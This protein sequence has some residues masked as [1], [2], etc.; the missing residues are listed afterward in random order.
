MLSSKKEKPHETLDEAPPAANP[1]AYTGSKRKPRSAIAP[2]RLATILTLLLGV[3][4]PSTLWAQAWLENPGAGSFQSGIGVVSGW[5]CN[6]NRIEV[7]FDNTIRVQAGY[8]TPRGDTRAVC[9]DDHNGFSLLLNWSLLGN[10]RRF[11][12]V[13]GRT[14]KVL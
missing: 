12:Q 1:A 2:V 5:A 13:V 3:S 6:A 10:G 4:T 9:G 8:G 11:F 14:E 7:V